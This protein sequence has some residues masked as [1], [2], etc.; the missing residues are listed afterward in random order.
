MSKAY[1]QP[2]VDFFSRM[3][4]TGT[5]SFADLNPLY[6]TDA[7][8]EAIAHIRKHAIERFSLHQRR[9]LRRLRLPRKL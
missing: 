8:E 9:Q 4:D 7:V 3:V 2:I 5:I 6:V 1:W